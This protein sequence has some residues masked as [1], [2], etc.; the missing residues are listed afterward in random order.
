M[1]TDGPNLVAPRAEVQEGKGRVTSQ[2][3][4]LIQ[5]IKGWMGTK[6]CFFPSKKN[7]GCQQENV[8]GHSHLGT[9]RAFESST[10]RRSV[11]PC[12]GA[13]LH[14]SSS[15]TLALTSSMVLFEVHRVEKHILGVHYKQTPWWMFGNRFFT[16]SGMYRM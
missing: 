13:T 3:S 12:A 11:C 6:S 7:P 10:R 2:E 9:S 8:N 1:A 14:P 5:C 4:E 16:P 15:T